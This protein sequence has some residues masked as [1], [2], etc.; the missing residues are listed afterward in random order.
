[1]P[2]LSPLLALSWLPL[3]SVCCSVRC[4]CAFQFRLSITGSSVCKALSLPHSCSLPFSPYVSPSLPLKQCRFILGALNSFAKR[5]SIIIFVNNSLAQ[6]VAMAWPSLRLR[7]PL[8]LPLSLSAYCSLLLCNE[9]SQNAFRQASTPPHNMPGG[10]MRPRCA[11]A[12]C[13]VTLIEIY[14][15][16]LMW[17]IASNW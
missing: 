1:M 13:D 12:M 8:P 7:L 3:I 2:S 14:W 10:N 11:H 6:C 5:L 9:L 16:H 17:K 15:K 4:F